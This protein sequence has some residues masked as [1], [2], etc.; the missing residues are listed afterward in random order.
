MRRSEEAVV[1]ISS[2]IFAFC[3][4]FCFSMHFDVE[5]CCRHNVDFTFSCF[6]LFFL[7]FFLLLS[8]IIPPQHPLF[9]RKHTRWRERR[10]IFVHIFMNARR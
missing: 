8:L 6:L 3:F 5:S 1:S 7:T 10:S 9:C 4:L 2:A